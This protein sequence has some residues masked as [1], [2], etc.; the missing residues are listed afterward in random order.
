[1]ANASNRETDERKRVDGNDELCSFS[2]SSPF[3]K[4][5]YLLQY[6]SLDR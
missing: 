1:M 6:Y 4:K 2:S 3:A 5:I